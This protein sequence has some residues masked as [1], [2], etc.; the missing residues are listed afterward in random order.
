V[1]SN[2]PSI[3]LFSA[4]FCDRGSLPGSADLT[5]V[6]VVAIGSAGFIWNKII[7][8]ILIKFIV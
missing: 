1:N 3:V 2:L 8:H 4:H 6:N 5:Q 7:I